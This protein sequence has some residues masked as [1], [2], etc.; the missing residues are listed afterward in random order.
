MR[1]FLAYRPPYNWPALRDFLKLREI[2][3]NE[4][5]QQES[6]Q[7][8]FRL[9]QESV[10]V[11]IQHAPEENGFYLTLDPLQAHHLQTLIL[12]VQQLSNA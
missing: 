12:K 10:I 6:M 5:I 7:K 4:N 2:S 3:E 8:Y 9:G 11:D 1:I